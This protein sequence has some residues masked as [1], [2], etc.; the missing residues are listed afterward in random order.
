MTNM[1]LPDMLGLTE[2]QNNVAHLIEDKTGF[3][4]SPE[5]RAFLDNLTR[6]ELSHFT[7]TKEYLV[8]LTQYLDSKT[9]ECWGYHY[10]FLLTRE[11]EFL[12]PIPLD[13]RLPIRYFLVPVAQWIMNRNHFSCPTLIWGILWALLARM[14]LLNPDIDLCAVIQIVFIAQD[15]SD[16]ENRLWRLINGGHFD[17]YYCK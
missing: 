4:P 8:G 7:F 11:A 3:P 5:F 10:N 14:L 15:L 13:T 1:N 16:M 17:E 12:L 2:Q 9:A 6:F